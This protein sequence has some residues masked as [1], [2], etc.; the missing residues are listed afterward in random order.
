MNYFAH[1]MRFVDRPYFLAGTAVPDWLSVADRSV[2]M[3]ERRVAP[4]ADHSGSVQ[5][6]VAAGVLQ[7]LHD[8]RWFHETR[9][10]LETTGEMARLFRECLGGGDGFRSGFLGHV[11][12]ELLLDAVLIERRPELLEQ[13]YA[14]LAAVDPLVVQQAVNSMSKVPTSRLAV[15]M[16]VFCREAFLWDYLEPHR[17]LARLNQVLQRIKLNPLPREIT[18]VLAAG[19]VL[20]ASRLAELLPEDRLR[21]ASPEQGIA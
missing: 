11:A 6:E 2:R 8:D 5:S 1:G 9:A 16:P 7:H 21:V 4:L 14:A 17:L 3:R 10:F 12:T 18:D 15:F 13:Y 19:R 20:V